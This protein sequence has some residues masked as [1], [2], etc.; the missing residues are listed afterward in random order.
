MST[1]LAL[2][3]AAWFLVIV[4]ALVLRGPLFAAFGAL[5]GGVYTFAALSVVPLVR[6]TFVAPVF[7]TLHAV[8]YLYLFLF[9]AQPR[10]RGL[11]YRVLVSFP[12]SY[13]VA[14]TVLALPWGVAAQLG[15]E[16]PLFI[17]SLWIPYLFAGI[18][19]LQSLSARRDEVHIVLDGSDAGPLARYR[20]K[21]AGPVR[22][23]RPL[24]VAQI[25]DPHLGPFMS[26][27]RLKRI[28]EDI[29]AADPDLVLLTGD[30]LT[31][32]S[33]QSGEHLTQALVP[34]R[35]LAGRTFACRGN[36]D[37]EAPEIVAAALQANGVHLL[38]DEAVTAS[39][40][41]GEVDLI[42]FDYVFR[43]RAAHVAAVTA[44]H[45]RRAAGIPRLALLHDP[46][47]FRH[48][49]PGTADL[50]FSGHLHGGQL[51]LFRAAGGWTVPRL[52][53]LPD[54]GLWAR[55]RDRI[56]VHRG[57]AHYGFPLRIGVPAEESILHLHLVAPN[58]A[59]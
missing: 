19:L 2:S 52:L 50:V 16:G 41:Y 27:A 7:L 25:S 28:C 53:S 46:G 29:V 49:P 11:V 36:H 38:I 20:S 58:S 59:Q 5:F 21:P 48:V 1:I 9:L 12:G 57:N 45:P 14:G 44:R 39:T 15:A 55:G 34:L 18:G 17:A 51:G 56:Y 8:A 37:L 3:L 10:M 47:C 42:G 35:T 13:F 23:A 30:F 22:A 24:R 54:H 33:Q 26:V 32:D 31:V 6:A 43:Q 40:P 4:T